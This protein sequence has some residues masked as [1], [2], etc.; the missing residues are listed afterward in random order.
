MPHCLEGYNRSNDCILKGLC[1]AV[2]PQ[3]KEHFVDSPFVPYKELVHSHVMGS[4]Q[5]GYQ[6]VSFVKRSNAAI[7]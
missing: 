1:V 6:S 3:M 4:D 5:L 7:A 2:E